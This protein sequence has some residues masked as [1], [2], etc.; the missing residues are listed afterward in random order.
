MPETVQIPVRL[1]SDL[2]DAIR[3]I[4]KANN[5][6]MNSEVLN[7]LKKHVAQFKKDNPEHQWDIF[8]K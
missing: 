4:A 1:D 8:T 2:K 7:V 3:V 5:R 6:S